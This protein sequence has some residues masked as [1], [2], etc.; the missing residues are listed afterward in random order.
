MSCIKVFIHWI[1]DFVR[2]FDYYLIKSKKVRDAAI[3]KISTDS[4]E[5]CFNSLLEI[6]RMGLVAVSTILQ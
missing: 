5:A 6:K 3:K 4:N 2:K 1:K